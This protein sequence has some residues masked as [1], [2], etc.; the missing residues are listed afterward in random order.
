[1]ASWHRNLRLTTF[2]FVV[3]CRSLAQMRWMK[4]KVLGLKREWKQRR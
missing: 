1:M 2:D 4:A 3:K